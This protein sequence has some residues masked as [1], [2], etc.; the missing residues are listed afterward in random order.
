MCP[1][2]G[3]IL[4]LPGIITQMETIMENQIS[5]QSLIEKTDNIYKLVRLVSKR[6]KE[7]NLGS[8]P[9]LEKPASKNYATI[10]LQEIIADKLKIVKKSDIET[11]PE[12]VK[13]PIAQIFKDDVPEKQD[14]EEETE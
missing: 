8:K 6:A 2:S 13:D 3:R 4:L 9:L 5:M 11:E 7:L 12:E 14:K 10:A 1:G